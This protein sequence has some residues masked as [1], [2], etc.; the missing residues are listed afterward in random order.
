[1]GRSLTVAIRWHMADVLRIATHLGLRWKGLRDL[2]IHGS[3]PQRCRAALKD[4]GSSLH[5]RPL[6]L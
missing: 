4:Y 6:V 2:E 1:M 5:G 3:V